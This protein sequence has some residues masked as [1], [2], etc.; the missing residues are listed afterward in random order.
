METSGISSPHPPPRSKKAK[1]V[2]CASKV[3]ASIVWDEAGVLL[4]DFIW[5]RVKLSPGHTTLI[6]WCNHNT[7]SRRV[8]V[9]SW[10]EGCSS[11]KTMLQ[12]TSQWLP[13]LLST[14]LWISV[15]WTLALFTWFVKLLLLPRPLTEKKKKISMVANLPRMMT[16]LML[17]I[18]FE[19]TRCWLLQ[20]RDP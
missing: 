20:S 19:G 6:F 8:D 17:W 1:T 4:V 16:L 2:P 9:G 14:Q 11:I 3:M 5:K 10:Q 15:A 7:K 18:S 13:W 12:L